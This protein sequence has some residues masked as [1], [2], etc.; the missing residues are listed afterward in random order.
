[1]EEEAIEMR[2]WLNEKMRPHGVKFVNGRMVDIAKG[3]AIE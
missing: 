1:M 3:K 2:K